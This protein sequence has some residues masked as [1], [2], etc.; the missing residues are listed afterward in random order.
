MVWTLNWGLPS[1][2]FCVITWMGKGSCIK[3]LSLYLRKNEY[4]DSGTSVCEE[5]RDGQEPRGTVFRALPFEERHLA[6]ACASL[7]G[8]AVNLLSK[9]V[10][11]S[12]ENIQFPLTC[13]FIPE[14]DFLPSPRHLHHPW[15]VFSIHGKDPLRNW[16]FSSCWMS[17]CLK[18][19]MFGNTTCF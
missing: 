18:V 14:S 3:T 2:S 13:C 16:H 12:M 15:K 7:A 8:A 5:D 4:C 11:C 19:K 1:S 6:S 9:R 10:A 17:L